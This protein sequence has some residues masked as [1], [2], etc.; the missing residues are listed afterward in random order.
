MEAILCQ[1]LGGGGD[2]KRGKHKEE[3]QGPD[4]REFPCYL[5]GGVK[6]WAAQNREGRG[7]NVQ[8]VVWPRLSVDSAL[9]DRLG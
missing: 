8:R 9:G 5:G 3:R 2:E 1:T 6:G 7:E 4:L